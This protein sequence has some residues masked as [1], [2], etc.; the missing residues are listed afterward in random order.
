MA[1]DLG[2]HTCAHAGEAAGSASIW[3]AVRRLQVERIGHGTRAGEDLALLDY[4]AESKLPLEMCPLSNIAT[5]VVGRIEEHPIRQFFDRGLRVTVNTDD[6]G[7]FGNTLG[8]E[9][10]LLVEKLGFSRDEIRTL[11]L[12]GIHSSWLLAD[13]KL[14]LERD[15]T[16]DPGWI[17][18]DERKFV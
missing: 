7:M 18:E 11:I 14:A 12:N 1:R 2:F 13:E 15:F 5:G 6:P 17:I 3:G 9:Y 8:G 4:L 10:R 16:S